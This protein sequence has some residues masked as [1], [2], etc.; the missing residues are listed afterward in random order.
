MLDF[1]SENQLDIGLLF[2]DEPIK[3]N[4]SPTQ[5]FALEI[6]SIYKATAVYFRLFDDARP[7]VPVIYIYDNTSRQLDENQYAEIQRN[8]WSSC[9]VPLFII[10][11]K[12]SVKIFDSR[13][14]VKIS[15]GGLFGNI[16]SA[17]IDTIAVTA[18]A[19]RQYSAKLFDNGSF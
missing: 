10:I 1:Q 11:E 4:I 13:R 14:P 19:L 6:A 16:S 17:P 5:L 15:E 18:E 9:I 3:D 7:P 12:A 2:V 8:L